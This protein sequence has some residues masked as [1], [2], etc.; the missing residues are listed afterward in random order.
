MARRLFGLNGAKGPDLDFHVGPGTGGA[1]QIS[2]GVAEFLIESYA[3]QYPPGGCAEW[4]GRIKCQLELPFE[5]VQESGDGEVV[6]AVAVGGETV[7]M[8]LDHAPISY[9]DF[10][11]AGRFIAGMNDQIQ[12]VVF[13]VSGAPEA[14]GLLDA[15]SSEGGGRFSEEYY[16]SDQ[17]EQHRTD[18]G[19][20]PP[21]RAGWRGV[22]ERHWSS[23]SGIAEEFGHVESFVG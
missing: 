8:Q 1:A 19:A 15:F 17:A 14:T 20:G 16:R 3:H 22:A 6:G 21:E 4:P 11:E 12:V 13:G 10:I 5:G 23:G 18:D 2:F 9:S 7:A